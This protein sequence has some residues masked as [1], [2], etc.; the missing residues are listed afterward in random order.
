MDL[1]VSHGRP[2]DL[3]QETV[4]LGRRCRMVLGECC[5]PCTDIGW[6]QSGERALTESRE[7]MALEKPPIKLFGSY[8]KVGPLLEPVPGER[9]KGYFAGGRIDPLTAHNVSR[10]C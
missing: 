6:R 5:V 1:L 9:F 10:L 3:R 4:R 7:N 2:H 8:R